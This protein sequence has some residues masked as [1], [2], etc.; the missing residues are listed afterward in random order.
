MSQSQA[1]QKLLN[2]LRKNWWMPALMVAALIPVV[3]I[4]SLLFHTLVELF[5]SGIALVCFIVAWNTHSQAHNQYLLMLGCGYFSVGVLDMMH[6]LT[7]G[8]MPFF[9]DIENNVTIQFWIVARFT[10]ALTLL[11]A[12]LLLHRKYQPRT[13]LTI[14]LLALLLATSLVV[15][16][17]LPVM[18]I[19]GEGLTQAKIISEYLI[20][21]ILLIAAITLH[22]RRQQL[23][24]RVL[25]LT[26]VS[27]AMTIAAEL[28]FTLYADLHGFSLVVGHF[29]KLLSFWAIYIA[30][31][32]S[33]LRQP[34]LNLA[35]DANTY[36]AIPDE[37]IL[38]DNKAIIRQANQAVRKQSGLSSAEIVGRHCHELQH[39]SHVDQQDCIICQS[40][41]SSQPLQGYQ[42]FD[43]RQQQ[44]YEI[45]LSHIR[46]GAATAGMV[47][48][49]R[50]ITAAKQAEKR[51]MTLNRLYSVMT[52]ANKVIAEADSVEKV[53]SDICL[54]ALRYGGFSMAW[55][56]LIEGQV[57]RPKASAGDDKGYLDRVEMRID[58]SPLAHGPVGT[59]AREN[60]V[61]C[62][63]NTITDPSFIPWR[64]AAQA[65]GFHSLA[66][67]P[68]NNNGSVIGICAFYSSQPDTFDSEMLALL[69]TLG[70]DISLA[71][72]RLKQ[73]AKQA[74]TQHKLSQLSMA[75]E[76]S[77]N[78]IVITD[79]EF[80]AEYVNRSFVEMTGF[81]LVEMQHDSPMILY[82]N[83][84]DREPINEL[85][86]VIRSGRQWDGELQITRKDGSV[87]WASQSISPL[88]DDTGEI[89]NYVSTFE[90]ITSLH[91]AQ[92]TIEK[93]AFFDP[94]TNLPNRR[95]LADRLNQAIESCK[96]RSNSMV[97]I[98]MF[99]LDNFKTVND[100]L[101]HNLGD[102][103]LQQV[104]DLFSQQVRKEDTVARLG[105]DE[106]T[107]IL[108]NMKSIG[109]I[110]EIAASI[111]ELL[112]K[113]LDVSEHQVVIGTSIGI[114]VYPGDTQNPDELIR[115]ADIAMY[116]AKSEGKNNF[117]FFTANMNEKVQLRLEM[118]N[119]L[120]QAIASQHFQLHY[121]PQVDLVTGAISG[122]EALIR[123][124]DPQRGII[125]P[126]EFIPLAEDTGMIGPI[127]DWV[128]ETACREVKEM[129]DN[130]F[131]QVKVAV[132]VSA[133]QFHHG[134]HLAE[135]I[136]NA[137]AASGLAANCLS[138]EVTESLLIDGIREAG[139]L[140]EE[141]RK[142]Q[143]TIA[144]DD[145]GTGYSSLSYLKQLPIDILKIDQSFIRDLLVDASDKAI[146][147]AIIAMA[148]KL[149]I[150]VLAEGVETTEHQNILMQQDCDFAQG[151]LY[152]HPLPK[153]ELLANWQSQ[154]ASAASNEYL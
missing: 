137:L 53:F 48:V 149:D 13:I 115:N 76:Q 62:V 113:P 144:I 104:A 114:S 112:K 148:H 84:K 78:A 138:L 87:F 89:V 12:P 42:Y 71:L 126:I 143:I 128:I 67:V 69:A 131:P 31:I 130:G 70:T 106:F 141:L 1:V 139:E 111:I 74:E 25:K 136:D 50:N 39:D 125:S 72:E 59:S 118:E 123:W 98:L 88:M 129:Q 121:Q 145:F 101:G 68:L 124:N 65:R 94:L 6:T 41:V 44:W 23:D 103:L 146:V 46:H 95:L 127:G 79:T 7:F 134:Q 2:H 120:R 152:C 151:Y 90:D 18:L 32:E 20:I 43:E 147:N 58:D 63:N 107:I 73:K 81:E 117:Q 77:D 140:L 75:V 135:V 105:G 61:T 119:R 36:D 86:W 24:A 108:N 82:S 15:F 52:Q 49:R 40:I 132:N 102:K 34:F 47:H 109:K 27:I 85:V 100:S 64:K 22:H 35:R 9:P 30:L 8:G 97:A 17:R 29:F 154:L 96:R 10:E 54:I 110:A 80:H 37:T 91:H 150:K 33:S 57:I 3:Q 38:V 116:H 4:N 11:L 5:A 28:A 66:S 83:T 99:D 14:A 55:I 60:R 45:S 16:E 56:G 21:L 133:Y 153:D 142:R 92:Q 26:Y 93:L 51:S 122:V 19:A